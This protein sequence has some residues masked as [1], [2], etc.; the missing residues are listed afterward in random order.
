M[1]AIAQG[2]GIAVSAGTARIAFAGN[3]SDFIGFLSSNIYGHKKLGQSN[4]L[5]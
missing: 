2:F 1:S 3:Y 4:S 5:P